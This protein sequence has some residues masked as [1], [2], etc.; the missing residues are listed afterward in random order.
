MTLCEFRPIGDI[1][2]HAIGGG[3]GQD[4]PTN[5]SQPVLVIRGADFPD[6]DLQRADNLP[7]RYEPKKKVASRIL[8][9]GDI[10]LEIS[11][12]TKD[13]PTGRTVYLTE[14]LLSHAAHAVIP[15]SFCRLVRVDRD[16]AD[17]RFVYYFLQDLYNAGGTWEF[18]NQSTGLS[19]FQF[20]L[21]RRKMLFPAVPLLTQRAISGVLG[22]LDEKIAANAATVD[23]LVQ[24][25][26]A[27]YEISLLH[28]LESQP[29]DEVAEFHNRKRVPLS[30]I[31]R[32]ERPGSI[33]YYGATGVF[34]SVDQSLF[35][36]NLVLVG[37]D[38]SVI[39][40]CGL[41]V[42]QYIWGPSWVNNH[43]HVLTGRSV[44]T[45]LLRFALARTNVASLVTG[46]VQP[47]I[48]MGKLKGLVLELPTSH[49]LLRI[50]RLVSSEMAMVRGTSD[51]T[52]TLAA[53]RDSLLPQLMS[54]R[55]RV[56]DVEHMVGDVV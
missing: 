51:E 14:R 20:E 1:M 10:V 3:W 26:V 39:T 37:E 12:G 8:E 38:G 17:P 46:A 31:E 36:D 29:L 42:I 2:L 5:G 55:I 53:M 50:E 18:Q 22:A 11:G 19:N 34:G 56:K 41:P 13:R 49:E 9:P 27:E 15:A 7:L 28:G 54:G 45:E 47:K 43:A 48:S 33:P 23:L 44:S 32:D 52:K 24:H 6:V 40:P 25:Q 4:E 35:N 16:Q 30:A 21:F